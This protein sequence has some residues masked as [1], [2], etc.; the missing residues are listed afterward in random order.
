MYI[1][2]GKKA[3]EGKSTGRRM[4]AQLWT[5]KYQLFLRFI[6]YTKY[7]IQNTKKIPKKCDSKP[8]LGLKCCQALSINE[9]DR[10]QFAVV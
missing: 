10:N 2:N 8:H 7:K 6:K 5:I 4:Q 1:I 3:Q 9:S